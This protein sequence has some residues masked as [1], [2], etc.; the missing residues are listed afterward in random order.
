MKKINIILLLALGFLPF[1]G[2]CQPTTVLMSDG[3]VNTCNGVLF[4]TGGQGAAGYQNNE[5]LTLT[6]CPDVPGD[7]ITIVFT[8]FA[9]DQT[10]TATPPA[11]NKDN[12]SI[13][14]GN[15]AAAPTLGTYTGNQLQGVVVTATAANLTG[16]LTL[17]FNSNSS[18]TGVFAGT[19]TCTTPCQPPTALFSS[20]TVPQNPQKICQGGTVN[21]DASGSTAQPTFT[22]VD[23]IF[24]YGDGV[25]DT[26]QTPFTSHAYAN[27]GEFLTQLY[28]ID[29][30]GCINMNSEIIKVWVSTTPIFNTDIPDPV[31]CLGESS[32]LDG[33]ANFSPVMYTPSPGSS[34]SGNAYLLGDTVGNSYPSTLNYS[35][36]NPGQTLTNINDLKEICITL[37][38]TYMGDM[39]IDITC[40]NGTNVV[41]HQQGGGGTDLGDPDIGTLVPGIGWDY[42]WSPTAINGTWEDNSTL[43]PTPS[44]MANSSAGQSLIPGTYESVNPLSALVG[45]PLNGTWTLNITDMWGGDDGS[46]F[47]FWIDL[48]TALY[49]SLTTFTPSI[50]SQGD[51]TYWTST[52]VASSYITSI[53]NDS[54]VICVTP[55]DTGTFNYTY[56]AI[57][58]FGCSYDTTVSITVVPGPTVNA[59][60][61]TTVCSGSIVQLN[62]Q[63]TNPGAVPCDYT[64][65]MYDDFGDGWNGFEVEVIINGTSIGN[66]TFTT[67]SL[68]SAFFSVNNGDNIVI[69]TV[70]GFYDIEVTFEIVD[71]A[72]NIIFSDGFNNTGAA[73]TIGN[74]VFNTIGS[75]PL[76]VYNYIWTPGAGL[77]NDTIANPTFSAIVTGTYVVEMWESNHQACSTFD[78]IVVTANP[79]ALSPGINGDTT[80]CR[81]DA[82]FDMFNVL[83]GTPDIGGV[84][85]DTLGNLISNMFDP[86]IDT[87]NTYWYFVGSGLCAD[88]ASVTILNPDS[89][90]ITNTTSDT[91]IC[92]NGTAFLY[93]NP[94]GGSGVLSLIWDNA[95][96]GNGPH[97]TSPAIPTSYQ[98]YAQDAVGCISATETINVTLFPEIVID[99][100]ESDTVCSVAPSNTTT[101][102]AI[103]VG[104]DGNGFTYQWHN[105][106]GNPIGGDTNTISITPTTSPETFTV[107]V[108]DNCST[109]KDT[110][111]VDIYWY[112]EIQPLF[113][114]NIIGDVCIPVDVTFTNSTNVAN[115]Q[116]I[117]W[118]FGDGNTSNVNPTTTHTYNSAGSYD[119][120]LSITSRDGCIKNSTTNNLV[121]VYGFPKALFS[122][123]PVNPNTNNT[124]ITFTNLSIDN[125]T[126]YWSFTNGNPN[127]S[128]NIDPVVTFPSDTAGT[129]PVELIVANAAGCRDTTIGQFVKIDGVYLF[130]MPNSF[131]PDGDGLNETFRA[132]GDA[133]ELTQYNIQ[134]FNK[135]GELMFEANNLENGW[136][137]TYKGKDVPNGVYI[138]KTRAKE[139]YTTIM[140]DN[141][142]YLNLIR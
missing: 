112:P 71:C 127:N 122:Y 132:Y 5:N 33:G 42:C 22:I 16:C 10:N 47:D 57:D 124:E 139:K 53:T 119:V 35:F 85:V 91:T 128:M 80:L 50:G 46:I 116:S 29:D 87:S 69:N 101:L 94:T 86:A 106:A 120:T 79:I 60:N 98:V 141:S 25:I 21:F 105:G 136:N 104:G 115:V 28:I 1:L 131:S 117:D 17:V 65:R 75:S 20:P 113:S 51:S 103:A 67:G 36:F 78:T 107:Y 24:D 59:G 110:M 9:L 49:P 13:Y 92:I 54:N 108:G 14:D 55:T 123:S 100:I 31:I 3:A 41:M 68:D 96:V 34:L 19:I 18:G 26:L 88:T 82:A 102:T 126:N 135:W 129:Y 62:A 6:I 48:D 138:W 44:T 43:G 23:Y 52:G 30:N 111:T 66:F 84:W 63:P 74:N 89:V 40:P 140:H 58:N 109:P 32:C 97:N 8:N 2:Y 118:D 99:P 70:S 4:D 39:V 61:D 76:L 15:T 125:D 27:P 83:N 134:I 142:G 81:T 56:N 37:E 73:P 7:I 12:L 90:L 38:H 95:L 137:G 11:N 93:A 130:Y 133:I 114:S 45:C 72:G 77:S 121:T 64:I